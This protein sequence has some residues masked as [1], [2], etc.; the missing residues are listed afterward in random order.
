MATLPA[1][2]PEAHPTAALSPPSHPEARTGLLYGLAA[3]VAW[4][5]FP[6]YFKAL[7]RAHVTPLHILAHR[8]VWSVLFLAALLW[9][10]RRWHEVRAALAS[11]KTFLTLIASSALI[12]VNWLIFIYAV[13]DKRVLEASLGYFTNPL[14][15]VLLGLIFLHERLRVLQTI[16]LALAALGVAILTRHIGT[17]P[18]IPLGLA[19]SFGFYA[20]LRKTTAAGPL[21]G[22]AVETALLLPFA[23]AFILHAQLTGR[24]RHPPT[25][26][27]LLLPSGII[28]ALPLLWF[29]SAARRLR[30]STIGFLQYL[31]PSCQFL[32]AVLLFGEAFTPTHAVTFTLIWTALVLYSI[33][34]LQAYRRS[35]RLAPV[36]QPLESSDL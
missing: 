29:A 34:S 32:L 11:R 35:T 28:T 31:A 20:L 12:A 33:D 15:N 18:W 21:V 17:F 23:A 36:N 1:R 19:L 9:A 24:V 16:A 4:G 14:V 27:L 2:T 25:T 6:L 8:I 30:L 5:V 7:D 3:Y 26:W 10:T 13:T 22:L